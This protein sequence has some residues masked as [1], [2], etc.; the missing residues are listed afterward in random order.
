MA[1]PGWRS[2][3]TA[4]MPCRARNIAVDNPTRLPPTIRTG[5][6]FMLSTLGE[7]RVFTKL[8]VV[9]SGIDV[10]YYPWS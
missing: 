7:L 8:L 3:V 9:I 10:S 5:L 2:T 6:V 4:S 1:V